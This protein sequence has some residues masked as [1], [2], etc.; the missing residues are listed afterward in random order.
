MRHI[1]IGSDSESDPKAKADEV[2]QIYLDGPHTEEA[3]AALADQYSTDPGSNTNGGLYENVTEGMMVQAFNDW[4]FA[5]G[6]K[7][8]DTGIV[9]TSYGYHI[10]YFV[11]QGESIEQ[12]D[13][14]VVQQKYTEWLDGITDGDLE[15]SNS[16]LEI[17]SSAIYD[18]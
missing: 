1:L 10:M 18:E 6:R 17:Y 9:E 15:V 3:F 12:A 16:D 13:E 5:A 14:T 7:P 8:G 2:Y 4:C 11:G